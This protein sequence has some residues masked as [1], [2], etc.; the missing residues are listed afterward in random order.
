[1]VA[2]PT[3]HD[4]ILLHDCQSAVLKADPS[5]EDT[6]LALEFLELQSGVRGVAPKGLV[7]APG[8]S[9]NVDGQVGKQTPELSRSPRLH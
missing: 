5:R 4:V 2:N 1:V 7:S 6:I 3:P 8:R 9:L